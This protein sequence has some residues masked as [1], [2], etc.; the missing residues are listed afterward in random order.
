MSF[1]S[2]LLT[3]THDLFDKTVLSSESE[4]VASDLV[5]LCESRFP[6]AFRGSRPVC[7]RSSFSMS[8]TEELN[9]VASKVV[10]ILPGHQGRSCE[11]RYSGPYDAIFNWR[12]GL[13]FI[14]L[15]GA[16]FAFILL[17]WDKATG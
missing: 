4:L 13:V 15:S 12:G 17:A 7:H 14:V 1:P 9:T 5:L 3:G 8:Q 6:K 10:Q 16:I 11:M 2:R